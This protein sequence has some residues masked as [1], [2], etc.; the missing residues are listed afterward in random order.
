M[1]LPTKSTDKVEQVRECESESKAG[2]PTTV[3]ILLTFH[4][5]D[6]VDVV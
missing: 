4:D 6:V 5:V 3:I 1:Q 2:Q